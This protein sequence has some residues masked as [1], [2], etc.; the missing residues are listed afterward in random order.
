MDKLTEREFTILDKVL[1]QTLMYTVID[2]VENE[3]GEDVF[4]DFEEHKAVTLAEG[5]AIVYDGIEH[6]LSYVGGGRESELL[7]KEEAKDLVELFKR[8]IPDII[9]ES[10]ARHFEDKKKGKDVIER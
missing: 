10:I 6:E 9:D 1:H 3:K 5:L 8:E 4:V 7:T 2:I